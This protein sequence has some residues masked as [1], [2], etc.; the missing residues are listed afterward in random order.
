VNDRLQTAINR[1]KRE[2]A[3]LEAKP[4]PQCC[5][6]SE[7]R[8]YNRAVTAR[9]NAIAQRRNLIAEYEARLSGQ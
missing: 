3:V 9:R 1:L 5:N 7:A 8:V 4:A 2:I 6:Y